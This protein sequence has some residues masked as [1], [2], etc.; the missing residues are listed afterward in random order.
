MNKDI[1]ALISLFGAIFLIWVFAL[2]NPQS[3]QKKKLNS[4]IQSYKVIEQQHVPESKI[5]FMEKKLDSLSL[6]ISKIKNQFYLDK[7]I[8]DLGRHIEQIGNEY[9]LEFKN[10]SLIDYEILNFF[11][12]EN[13]QSL[14]ELPVQI[15]FEGEYNALTHF[16]DSIGDFPFLIR[17]TDISILNDDLRT[18]KLSISLIGM[19]VITKSELGEIKEISKESI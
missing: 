13:D 18:M 7:A 12:S 3:H 17:F 5:F 14:T 10:I 16:L 9:G 6:E 2:F 4:E 11:G 1:I 19:V 8:L 15:E